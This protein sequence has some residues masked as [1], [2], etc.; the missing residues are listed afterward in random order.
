MI[1]SDMEQRSFGDNVYTSKFNIDEADMDQSD[2]LKN[3]VEFN[4]KS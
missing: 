1:F 2:L 3:I 4:N